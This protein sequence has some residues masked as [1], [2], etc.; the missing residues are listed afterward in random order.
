MIMFEMRWHVI[1][2]KVTTKEVKEYQDKFCVGPKKARL[3]LSNEQKRLEYR[4]GINKKWIVVPTVI[5]EID[6][7]DV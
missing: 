5:S 4:T 7:E 2:N 3:I 1:K 6:L